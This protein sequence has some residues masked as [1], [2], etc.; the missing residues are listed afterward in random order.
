MKIFR[1]FSYFLFLLFSSH[2]VF[3]QNSQQVDHKSFVLYSVKNLKLEEG[4]IVLPDSNSNK[5]NLGSREDITFKK[6]TTINANIYGRGTLEFDKESNFTGNITVNNYKNEKKDIVKG[7]D[8]IK[9]IG[10]IVANGDIKLKTS[11]SSITG[12]VKQRIGAKYE[13]P[14]PTLGKTLGALTL[15]IFPTLP[16][17]NEYTA[18]TVNKSGTQTLTP[19]AY[20]DIDLKDNQTLTLSGVGVYIFN[21]LKM[22]GKDNVKLI[23]DFK[24]STTGQF[25]IYV[26]EKIELKGVTVSTKNGGGA[27]R[28]F[29]E[30]HY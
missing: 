4:L 3:S 14:N 9:I 1:Q 22:D 27:N 2:T 10:N 19:G 24:N 12:S 7:E 21:S 30:V 23:Y 26:V 16:I 29:T 18:G 8:K 25:R 11:G 17:I 13:G 15:P 28:I 5:G 20:K 6:S